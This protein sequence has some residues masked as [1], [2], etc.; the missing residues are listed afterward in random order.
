MSWDREIDLHNHLGSPISVHLPS[1]CSIA[2]NALKMNDVRLLGHLKRYTVEQL[3]DIPY[4]GWKT[5]HYLK[6]IDEDYQKN[7]DYS[8]FKLE[9]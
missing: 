9:A 6:M 1:T 4:V 5:I 8:L 3:E 2:V 7:F